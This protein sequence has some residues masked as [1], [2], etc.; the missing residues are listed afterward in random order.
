MMK[1]TTQFAGAAT[2]LVRCGVLFVLSCVLTACL[3]ESNGTVV[4]PIGTVSNNV[5]PDEIRDMLEDKIPIYEGNDIPDIS[6]YYLQND[7]TALYCSDEGHGGYE[8][9]H[10]FANTYMYFGPQNKSGIIYEYEEK[11]A[12]S[13]STS[14][15]V[16]VMGKDNNFTAFYVAEG[17]ADNN[18]DGV[19]E[20]WTKTSTVISGTITPNGIKNYKEAFIMVEAKDPLNVIMAENEYRVFYEADGLVERI[21]KWNAPA[22]NVSS[23]GNEVKDLPLSISQSDNTK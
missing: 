12:S 4:L 13:T 18:N 11:Q 17:Y 16:Q 5:I 9:G 1:S 10:K 15:L 8:P 20:T 22:R 19:N 6:G 21:S 14:H 3:D 23:T 7:V 2:H